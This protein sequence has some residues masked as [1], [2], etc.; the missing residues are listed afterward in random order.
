MN[1]EAEQEKIRNKIAELE[2]LTFNKLQKMMSA[3]GYQDKVPAHIKEDNATKLAKILQE[4]DFFDKE[5]ARLLA[6]TGNQQME[7]HNK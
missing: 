3:S 4:F 6:E 5:S 2:N 1:A 7:E